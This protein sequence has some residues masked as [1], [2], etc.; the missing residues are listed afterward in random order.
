MSKLRLFNFLLTLAAAAVLGVV[1][2]RGLDV[3][4]FLDEATRPRSAGWIMMLLGSYLF[5]PVPSSMLMTTNGYWFGPALGLVISFSSSMI[6]WIS[7]YWLGWSLGWGV[8]EPAINRLRGRKATAPAERPGA[9]V[10]DRFGHIGISLLIISR[11]VPVLAGLTAGAAGAMRMK[12]WK[13]LL[14]AALGVLPM[15]TVYVLLG[16]LYG[17]V[18]RSPLVLTIAVAAPALLYLLA[19]RPRGPRPIAE[20]SPAGEPPATPRPQAGSQPADMPA[21]G[22]R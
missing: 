21:S 4:D 5:L 20:P 3:R 7:W 10:L 1:I 9:W 17:P 16:W 19:A 8:L 13:F 11:P 12:W 14:G 2:W 22:R 6:A 15:A 18:Y